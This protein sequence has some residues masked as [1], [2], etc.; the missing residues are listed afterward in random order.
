ML[1]LAGT[2]GG[3][4]NLNHDP[5][6]AKALGDMVVV[7][8][9]AEQSLVNVLHRMSSLP[10]PMA[11]AA[12]Y[13]IPTFEA[14]VKVIRAMLCEWKT[15]KYDI[16]AI[17]RA[18]LKLNVLARTR[19]KYV[20]RTWLIR[21]LSSETYLC[22]YRTETEDPD[23]M[24]LVNVSVVRNHVSAVERRAIALWQITEKP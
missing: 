15:D 13:K 3:L 4:R 5:E 24:E 14:R 11:V 7:W 6:L 10:Y 19:N 22:N 23:R 21:N 1:F 16:K 9:N 8:S 18:V 20:H 12:Y 17:D 2:F